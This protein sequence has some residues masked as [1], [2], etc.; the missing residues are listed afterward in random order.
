MPFMFF[1]GFVRY[2]ELTSTKANV[3]LP[4][5]LCLGWPA[6]TPRER[7]ELHGAPESEHERFKLQFKS[8]FYFSLL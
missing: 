4:V 3:D 2:R 5:R 8:N 1:T 6:G 7:S